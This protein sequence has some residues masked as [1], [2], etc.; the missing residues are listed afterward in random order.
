M[1]HFQKTKLNFFQ[2]LLWGILFVIFFYGEYLGFSGDI[3]GRDITAMHMQYY[4]YLSSSDGLGILW[5]PYSHAG[6][7]GLGNIALCMFYPINLL[8]PVLDPIVLVR[9]YVAV[10]L[11]IWC[12]GLILWLYSLGFSRKIVLLGMC[13]SLYSLTTRSIL[14]YGHLTI[15][16]VWSFTPWFLIL[17]QKLLKN[18]AQKDLVMK[19]AF[20]NRTIP[21]LALLISLLFIGAHPQM[22][23]QIAVSGF[24][25]TIFHHL[26][27]NRTQ[28]KFFIPCYV[29]SFILGLLP[30]FFQLYETYTSIKHTGRN[31]SASESAFNTDGVMTISI[32]V[33]TLFPFHWGISGSYWGQFDFWFGHNYIGV[34]GI[35]CLFLIPFSW[36]KKRILPFLFPVIILWVLSMG[37]QTPLHDLYLSTVPGAKFFRLPFRHNYFAHILLLPLLLYVLQRFARRSSLKKVFFIILGILF[38]YIAVLVFFETTVMSF[39]QNVLPEN[40]FE[41]LSLTGL[42]APNFLFKW[43]GFEILSTILML[44]FL[45]QKKSTV[46]I[47]ILLMITFMLFKSLNLLPDSKVSPSYYTTL[48]NNKPM[49]RVALENSHSDH[50]IHLSYGLKSPTGYD[51]LSLVSYRQFLDTLVAQDWTKHTREQLYDLHSPGMEFLG[52]E[53]IAKSVDDLRKGPDYWER[54]STH[55]LYY[56]TRSFSWPGR[57]ESRYTS[58]IKEKQKE[59]QKALINDGFEI[60]ENKSNQDEYVKMISY[61]AERIELEVFNQS[62]AL[63]ASSENDYPLW[64]AK[65]NGVSTTIEKWF[66][67]FRAIPLKAGKHTVVF[68][69]NRNGFYFRLFFSLI[70]ALMLII[71]FLKIKK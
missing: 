13:L 56:L 23:L 62:D 67:T 40:V 37:S 27:V 53:Y 66:G 17:C 11:L 49:K 69:I 50:N 36:K 2:D 45:K 38:F 3:Y 6:S 64:S 70:T 57:E 30:S 19:T 59:L 21:T 24:L 47:F 32:W 65:V 15:L 42:I 5:N 61:H 8:A 55:G 16:S 31:L 68:E 41:R 14:E 1:N 20:K 22:V 48:F 28:L 25:Y 63:L 58:E 35:V 10:H 29:S 33:K 43:Y 26:F 52:F 9:L 46:S 44:F 51:S 71:W 4:A 12:S 54:V 39:Y 18:C 34:I 60:Q 7:P